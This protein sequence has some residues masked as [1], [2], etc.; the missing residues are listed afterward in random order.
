MSANK[1]AFL[2]Y[3]EN[4]GALYS[5]QPNA[6]DRMPNG[7]ITIDFLAQPFTVK[8]SYTNEEIRITDPAHYITSG[9]DSTEMPLTGDQIADLPLDYIIL[10]EGKATRIPCSFC[11]GIWKWQNTVLH[12]QCQSHSHSCVF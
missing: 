5:D 3:I 6:Y 2:T 1:D 4:G 10:A 9:L 12:G 11:A 7:D 8:A